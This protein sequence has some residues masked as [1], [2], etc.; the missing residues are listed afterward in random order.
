MDATRHRARRWPLAGGLLAAV[1]LGVGACRYWS[2]QPTPPPAT[3][4]ATGPAAPAGPPIF[5]EI[6]D[7]A[8]IRHTYNNGQDQGHMAILESLGGGAALI[9]FDGDG[10]LDMVLTGGGTF[11]KS[12]K[13]YQEELKAA[14]K[15]PSKTVVPPHILGKP[16]KLYKNLGHGKFKDVT[17]EVGLDRPLFYTHGCAVADYDRDGWPDLLLTGWGRVVLYHNEPVDPKDPSKGRHFVDVTARAGLNDHLWSS[18]AAWGDL[19][20]DGYPDLYICHYGNWGFDKSKGQIHP[21]FC[22]YDTKHRDVCP[23]KQFEALPHIL[24]HNN[25]DGTFTDV[26]KSAGLRVPRTEKD[27]AELTWLS[28]AGKNVLRDA[29]REHQ[30][31]KGLGVVIGDVNGDGKP[32]IYVANDTV[33]NFLYINR[34]I[35]GHIR[36]EEKGLAAAVARDD[37]GIANGSMGT[38]LA[39]CFN[40]G[41]PAI[42]C[43]NYEAENHALYENLCQG[44]REYFIFATKSAGISAIGQQYVGWGTQFI[45]LDHDG[46]LDLFITNGHAIRFPQ[47]NNGVRAERP[48]LMRNLGGPNPRFVAITEQGGPYFQKNHVGRGAAFGDLDNDGRIDVVLNHLNEPAAVL[49]NEAQTGPNHWLGL[50]LA[51]KDHADIVGARILLDVDGKLQTRYAKG[52]GSYASANDPRHVFGLGPADHYTQLKVIWPDGREQSWEGLAVDRYWRLVEGKKEAQKP[53]CEK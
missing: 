50:E 40:R 1:L 52:G 13:V 11:D 32:D 3:V 17:H 24:Y 19:D 18:S 10:L 47:S 5:R 43:T 34:S 20:G 23:P 12:D 25:G 33:D 38:D 45:D 35:P 46:W 16:C 21:L 51:G 31:G 14:E 15:D 26:S 41:R 30:Y 36:L 7:E 9:D 6:T 2:S 48:V 49:H 42:W 8:G 27:Y 44:G 4:T 53:P 39:D 37:G 28:E 22:S 29:D